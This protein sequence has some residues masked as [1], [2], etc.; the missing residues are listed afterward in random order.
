MIGHTT[1][2]TNKGLALY[3][4]TMQLRTA[5]PEDY[6]WIINV[7]DEWWGRPMTAGLPHLFLTH[8]CSTSLVAESSDSPIG[9]L[10]G[11]HSPSIPSKAYIHF[12]AVHPES[13]RHSVGRRLYERFFEMARASGQT[14][15]EAVTASFNRQSIA[16]HSKLGF[17]VSSPID[18]YDGPGTSLV[19]FRRNL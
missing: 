13:R 4:L 3:S 10:V 7:V 8:F 5:T 12:V 18:N 2:L 14:Q 6:E 1:L 11:F 16:F 19:T 15:V 17:S 9:F